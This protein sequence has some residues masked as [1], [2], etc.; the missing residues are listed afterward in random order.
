MGLKVLSFGCG[1]QTVTLAAMSC[2]GELETP[3][4]AVF[5]DTQWETESTYYYMNYFIEWVAGRLEI[6]KVTAGNIR[7]DALDQEKRFASI[8]LYTE[9]GMLISKGKEDG[10][11]RRQCTREY[12][13][14][15]VQKLIRQKSGLGFGEHWR[16][17]PVE[18]WLGISLDEVIRMKESRDRWIKNRWPL[19]EK[20]MTRGDCI[21]WLK[22]HGLKVPPKSACIGCPFH[23]N[24]Y[25]R[26]LK[27]E[28][29]EEWKGVCNFDDVIRTTRVAL[30][31]PVYLHRTLRPL[32]DANIDEDQVDMFGNECEGYCGI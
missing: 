13:I 25:W 15:P 29:P 3:D 16:G 5:A 27:T 8:P 31:N 23:S 2:L 19:I 20:R 1:V 28:S 12:K 9:T 32:R 26:K 24:S 18:L 22:S 11:L 30:R 10:R 4:Y 21:E 6:H 17:E 7:A 14:S